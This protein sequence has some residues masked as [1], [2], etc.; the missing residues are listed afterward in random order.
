MVSALNSEGT[1]LRPG[2]YTDL[3]SLVANEAGESRPSRPQVARAQRRGR[4]ADQLGRRTVKVR[5]TTSREADALR[6]PRRAQRRVTGPGV[7]VTLSDAPEEVVDAS[8]Q[9]LNLLVVHQQDIQA[10]VNAMWK[11]G[12]ERGHRPGPADRQHHGHQVRGQ[13]RAARRACPYAQPYVI[14]AVGDQASLLQAIDDDDYL[15]ASTAS[16]PPSPASR[17]AGTAGVEAA[18]LTAPAYDGLTRHH[19]RQPRADGST[20]TG[21][22]HGVR[23]DGVGSRWDWSVGGRRRGS[24]RAGLD[25]RSY[26][27]TTIV[28][29]CPAGCR[30]RASGSAR[31]P[32]PSGSVGR[33]DVG[34]HVRL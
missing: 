24:G 8:T 23:A 16:R 25:V 4:P 5:A 18:Q 7:T 1:D 29:S 32:C 20:A 11:G 22:A 34:D 28:T 33:V 31:A 13:R 2:R 12:A 27:D 17:S 26:D 9:D 14:S 19:L 30:C 3:A 21:G 6:G 10:V 15:A